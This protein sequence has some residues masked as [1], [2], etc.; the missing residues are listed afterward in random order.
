M[1]QSDAFSLARSKEGLWGLVLRALSANLSL[2]VGRGRELTGP[3]VSPCM[4]GL[5][6]NSLCP[7]C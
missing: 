2:G 7:A 5:G 6:E 3:G 4:W 1:H